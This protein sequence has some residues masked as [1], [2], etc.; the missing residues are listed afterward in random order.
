M[1]LAD[2]HVALSEPKARAY[3][4][5]CDVRRRGHISFDEF[6]L[7]LYT[8]DPKH[9][10]RSTGFAPGQSLAPKNL[11]EMFDRD[12]QGALDRATFLELL[13]FLGKT[14][15]LADAEAIFAANEDV[16][17]VLLPLSCRLVRTQWLT[18]RLCGRGCDC[19]A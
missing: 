16:C 10:G 12:E 15:A 3:F 9:P 8:C 17:V 5:R 6:R 19:A 7:A 13:A 2:L 11:F 4:R 18:L 14:L 1:L